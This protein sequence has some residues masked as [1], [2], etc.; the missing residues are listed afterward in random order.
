MVPDLFF[1]RIPALRGI[2]PLLSYKFSARDTSYNMK[3][4]F[5]YAMLFSPYARLLRSSNLLSDEKPKILH[6]Y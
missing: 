1:L 3:N 2:M 4:V 6:D 5:T